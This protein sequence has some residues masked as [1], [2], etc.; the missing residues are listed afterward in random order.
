MT[1]GHKEF[2][3]NKINCEEVNKTELQERQVIALEQI[4]S[5]LN[6]VHITPKGRIGVTAMPKPV[7]YEK[8]LLER[9]VTALEQTATAKMQESESLV[10]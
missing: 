5:F 2:M 9:L 10:D 8:Q 7:G 6:S 3:R 1:S 4:A